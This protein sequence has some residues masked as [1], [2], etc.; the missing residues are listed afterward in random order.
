[1]SWI[2]EGAGWIG[3]HI[4]GGTSTG[5]VGGSTTV[6]IGT[7]VVNGAG[8]LAVNAV[9]GSGIGGS[10]LSV[11]TGKATANQ[12][13][14]AQEVQGLYNQAKSGDADAY[15]KL[16]A[17]TDPSDDG[18]FKTLPS[19]AQFEDWSHT[20]DTRMWAAQAVQHLAMGDA[21]WQARADDAVSKLSSELGKL[22]DAVKR[23][24]ANTVARVGAGAGVAG[25]T[26]IDPNFTQRTTTNALLWIAAGVA[27][28][29]LVARKHG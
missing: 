15:A 13:H 29:W 14:R 24:A 23:D 16:I 21:N 1:M 2:T 4:G 20:Q 18:V 9:S 3:S 26:A 25:A 22:T 6:P 28:V 12:V 19:G 27:V 8:N 7:Q 5:P 17:F 11:I 10:I